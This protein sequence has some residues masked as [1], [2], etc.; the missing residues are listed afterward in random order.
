MNASGE[1]SP[2]DSLERAIAEF[3]AAVESGNTLD[4]DEFLARHAP[5]AT[6]LAEFL[7]NH[8]R[9][10]RLAAPLRQQP[11]GTPETVIENHLI[12]S[13]RR[14][15]PADTP[16]LPPSPANHDGAGA[17]L[18]DATRFFGSYEL[19]A[20]I[21]RGGMGVV[22]KAR[23][24]RLNRV[25][26]LK[27]ILSG[28]LASR[29][30]VRRFYAEAEAAA[31]LDHP[32]IVPVY[33]V[34]EHDGQH[35][36]T[37]GFV[38]GESLAEVLAR[39]PLPPQAAAELLKKLAEAVAYAHSQGVLHRDL[40]PA[41]VLLANAASGG[42]K[43]P[44]NVAVPQDGKSMGDLRHP[45]AELIPKITDFGLAKRLDSESS[46]TATGQILGTPSYM[47]PEQAAGKVD[48]V[49]ETADVYSLGAILYA[50]LTGR[51]PFAAESPLDIIVQVLESEPTLPNKVRQ[52]IPRELEWICLRCL[53]KDPARR[54]ATAA[55]LAEDLGR[56]LRQEPVEARPANLWQRVRRWARREPALAAH[57]AGVLLTIAIVQAK[58][59]H[60]HSEVWYHVRVSGVL[61]AWGAS[62]FVFQWLLNRDRW[63]ELA[64]YFW[65]AADI[66]FLTALL[67]LIA[68]P[69][70]PLQVGYPLLIAASGL[71]FRVR[72]V[73]FTAILAILGDATLWLS[74]WLSRPPPP[75]PIHYAVL[76]WTC[77]VILGFVVG[78]QVRRMRVLSRYY[79]PGNLA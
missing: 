42:R 23:H 70:G 40:K 43:S 72:L 16:T 58:F 53:E 75:P 55:A 20:E 74:Q 48:E 44:V 9:L 3:L 63:S 19:L 37:M 22:Y 15:S 12:C 28:N 49:R 46:L 59:V 36:F 34:D 31:G 5:V 51:P 45:L 27:M 39:G 14:S 47:P 6:E 33:E 50:T 78:Y 71:F 13:P 41:N 38:E 64:R 54:Y 77:L 11:P 76:F 67:S 26:A 56:F 24:L 10:S 1:P 69:L 35:Y 30:D 29:D 8:D 73:A 66:L 52:G 65:S 2:Q 57:L 18:R 21:A 17:A 61:L 4:R 60:D 68:A 62:A 25:V 7:E 79:E 32:G